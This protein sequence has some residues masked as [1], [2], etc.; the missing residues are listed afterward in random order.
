MQNGSVRSVMVVRGVDL[1]FFS[2]WCTLHS[3]DLLANRSTDTYTIIMVYVSVGSIK[4][5]SM[6]I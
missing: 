4:S 1:L 3:L 2:C 5:V 6:S